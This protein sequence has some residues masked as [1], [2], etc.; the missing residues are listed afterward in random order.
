MIN[1]TELVSFLRAPAIAPPKARPAKR[2]SPGS[3]VMIGNAALRSSVANA[4][5]FRNWARH[6]EWVRA[7]IDIRKDQVARADWRIT[8]QD[9]EA[10]W[11]QTLAARIDA[12]I[13]NPNPKDK[14]WDRFIDKVLEDFLVLDAGAFEVVTNVRG[15]PVELWPVDAKTVRLNPAWDGTDPEEWRYSWHPNGAITAQA[16]WMDLEFVYMTSTPLTY[17]E[18]GLSKLE[19]LK[20]VV[21]SE[22][23]TSAYN[24]R[25]LRSA[26]PDGMLSLGEGARPDMVDAFKAMW[27]NE[28]AGRGTTAIV[29]GTRDPKWIPFR[30]SNRDMQFA[31]WQLYLVRKLTAVYGMNMVDLGFTGDVNRATAQVQQQNTEDRGFRPTLGDI[32]AFMT[33]QIVHHPAFGGPEN[34]L[35]FGFTQLNLKESE[36]TARVNQ[37]ALGGTPWKTVDEARRDDGR[38]PIGGKIGSS[39]IIIV[40]GIG[41]V[42]ADDSTPT[43]GE[44]FDMKKTQAEKPPPAPPAAASKDLVLAGR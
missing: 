17:Q 8:A 5:L 13:R 28:V 10:A 39:L 37:H 3:Q 33:S 29:G 27:L 22:L 40:P 12:L 35:Q 44:V 9:P 14:I 18:V 11:S 19:T 31:E 1:P 20:V 24:D 6:S 38:P 41:P 42:I 23:G 36:Q 32:A 21:D 25:Q 30:Q 7:I 2:V 15:E 34:N 16:T 26:A 43:A 4:E